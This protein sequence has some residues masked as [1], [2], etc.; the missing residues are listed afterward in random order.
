MCRSG[1]MRLRLTNPS[2]R[3][4][5]G[6]SRPTKLLR[7]SLS[8]MGADS[9]LHSHKFLSVLRSLLPNLTRLLH[10]IKDVRGSGETITFF[11]IQ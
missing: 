10:K 1:P 4:R 9:W 6:I 7:S 3:S 2:V 11:F 5:F 8:Y